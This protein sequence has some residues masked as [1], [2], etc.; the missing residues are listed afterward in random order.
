MFWHY[1]LSFIFI[2]A[3]QKGVITV[4]SVTQKLIMRE[5]SYQHLVST[6]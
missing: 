1:K 4:D 2:I 6:G 3:T 5:V